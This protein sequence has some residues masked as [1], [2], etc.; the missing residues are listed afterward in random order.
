MP[1][2]SR[3]RILQLV[4]NLVSNAIRYTRP[5]TRIDVFVTGLEAEA[6][7]RVR[8]T[9]RDEGPGMSEEQLAQIFERFVRLAAKHNLPTPSTGLGLS[10]V[11]QF[12]E[13]HGGRVWAESKVGQGSTFHFTLEAEASGTVTAPGELVGGGA[14]HPAEANQDHVVHKTRFPPDT[15]VELRP[16]VSSDRRAYSNLYLAL[17]SARWATKQISRKRTA[18][19]LQG[20]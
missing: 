17:A 1:P 8:I 2:E 15:P 19:L 6:G 14:P 3:E 12:V 11:K 4:Q 13:I 9:V 16:R 7:R 5:S 18:A 10:I 20:H